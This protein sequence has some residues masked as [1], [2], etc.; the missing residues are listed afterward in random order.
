MIQ[1]Q[2][3]LAHRTLLLEQKSS[4][5]RA[6]PAVK[7]GALRRWS[8]EVC[9]VVIGCALNIANL[10]LI[11]GV[12]IYAM[13]SEG[14]ASC[15]HVADIISAMIAKCATSVAGDIR[16]GGNGYFNNVGTYVNLSQ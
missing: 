6:A 11:D 12:R 1:L 5:R 4:G 14:S 13:G 10:A 9:T 15:A 7:A 8:I 2:G 16:V 3:P